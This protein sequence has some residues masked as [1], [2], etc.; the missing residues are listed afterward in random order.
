LITHGDLVHF[1]FNLYREGILN[2]LEDIPA[3]ELFE[4]LFTSLVS[5]S[6]QIAYFPFCEAF[7]L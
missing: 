6:Q 2:Y 1:S 3:A 4:Q 5:F 7:Y